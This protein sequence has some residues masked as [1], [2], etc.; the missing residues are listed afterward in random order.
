MGSFWPKNLSH[1][2]GTKI[3]PEIPSNWI[4]FESNWLNFLGQ[5]DSILTFFFDWRNN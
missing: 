2:S 5:N 3:W 1:Y 4:I